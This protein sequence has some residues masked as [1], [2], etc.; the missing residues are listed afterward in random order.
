MK[1][2]RRELATSG[3]LIEF[4]RDLPAAESCVSCGIAFDVYQRDGRG[5][6]ADGG[7]ALGATT[8]DFARVWLRAPLG[9]DLLLRSRPQR[10][11]AQEDL[12]AAFELNGADPALLRRW[13]LTA[14]LVVQLLRLNDRYPLV[15]MRDECID[16]GPL[17]LPPVENA[18][19]LAA[20]IEAV[21]T[22][23]TGPGDAIAADG[24]H[25]P[26]DAPFCY[27]CGSPVPKHAGACPQCGE[28]LDESDEE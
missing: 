24:A 28:R 15:E 16:F 17:L 25:L 8:G 5:G 14:P 7:W 12:E 2:A 9:M 19:N 27:F 23:P 4:F 18:V 13:R 6:I 21:A 20:L 3:E 26:A 22:L 11:E 10:V 1:P